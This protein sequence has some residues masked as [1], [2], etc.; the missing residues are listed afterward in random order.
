MVTNEMVGVIIAAAVVVGGFAAM[1]IKAFKPM[2]DL[3][4]SIIRLTATIED[5]TKNAEVQNT[6]ITKHG[7]EIDILKQKTD[8]HE[9]R[10]KY[11]EG[12]Q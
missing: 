4:V 11:L 10:I 7:S 6:R 1:V 2:Y 3:N 9:T 5:L 8:N 12:H